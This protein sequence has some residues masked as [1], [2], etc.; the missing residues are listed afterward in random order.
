MNH[1]VIEA[2][3]SA[4]RLTKAQSAILRDMLRTQGEDVASEALRYVVRHEKGKS[5]IPRVERLLGLSEPLRAPQGVHH[6]A[7]FR[8]G[9]GYYADEE[10]FKKPPRGY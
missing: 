5:D 6:T 9:L 4:A 3:I 2:I 7:E 1:N 8:S 10:R